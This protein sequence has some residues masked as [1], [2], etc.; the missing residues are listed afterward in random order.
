M[1]FKSLML[2]TPSVFVA[3]VSTEG[4][5]PELVESI[6]KSVSVPATCKA[7]KYTNWCKIGII[8]GLLK[9]LEGVLKCGARSI[10][11]LSVAFW[12]RLYAL[13]LDSW[14]YT[15][16][17]AQ[18]TD[19]L[20]DNLDP[21]LVYSGSGITWTLTIYYYIVIYYPCWKPVIL[22]ANGKRRWENYGDWH[23]NSCE[24]KMASFQ[25]NNKKALKQQ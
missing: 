9:I 14:E 2:L 8:S 13:R 1:R 24:K 3:L 16:W 21:P 19:S 23:R 22:P 7:D 4:C 18:K 17:M 11:P 10:C 12:K 5:S 15:F 20:D 6:T 25:A